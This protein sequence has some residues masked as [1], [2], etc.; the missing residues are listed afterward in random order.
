[1][2][3]DFWPC[4]SSRA[5]SAGSSAGFVD[6]DLH[7]LLRVEDVARRRVIPQVVDLAAR[8]GDLVDAVA[9]LDE[10]DEVAAAPGRSREL[11]RRGARQLGRA[12]RELAQDVTQ[13]EAG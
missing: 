8:L 10:H 11:R 3:S 13:L 4:C 6:A 7:G 1:M 5:R 9:V 2:R 12:G